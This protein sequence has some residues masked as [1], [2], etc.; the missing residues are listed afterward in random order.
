MNIV[1]TLA[2]L[3]ESLEEGTSPVDVHYGL[4]R[5]LISVMHL[6]QANAPRS[7]KKHWPEKNAEDEK[8]MMANSE[9]QE[10]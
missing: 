4:S 2:A 5:L 8:A 1:S 10:A 3:F 6:H 7:T 9:Y